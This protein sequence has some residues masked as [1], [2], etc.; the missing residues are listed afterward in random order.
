MYPTSARAAMPSVRQ[1][2]PKIA[3]RPAVGSEQ[4]EQQA[5]GGGLA[6]AVQAEEAED[7]SGFDVEVEPLTATRRPNRFVRPCVETAGVEG[8]HEDVP[9]ALDSTPDCPEGRALAGAVDTAG[10]RA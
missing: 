1:S 9:L 7:L 10:R 2:W 5:D 8:G 4:V 3:A 6:G